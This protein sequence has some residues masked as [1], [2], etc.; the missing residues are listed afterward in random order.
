MFLGQLERTIAN[1]LESFH[2]QLSRNPGGIGGSVF[3]HRITEQYKVHVKLATNYFVEIGRREMEMESE[4]GSGSGSESTELELTTQLIIERYP[5]ILIS[6]RL[7]SLNWIWSNRKKLCVELQDASIMTCQRIDDLLDEIIR[8]PPFAEMYAKGIIIKLLEY[9]EWRDASEAF[10]RRYRLEWFLERVLQTS[11]HGGSGMHKV[12]FRSGG[13]RKSGSKSAET[14][15]MDDMDENSL[16]RYRIPHDVPIIFIDSEPGLVDMGTYV[17]DMRVVAIDCEWSPCF[18]ELRDQG[19]AL[20]QIGCE[21]KNG[22][23]EMSSR[24]LVFIID[25]LKADTDVSFRKALLKILVPMLQSPRI[26]KL[27]FGFGEDLKMLE[28]VCRGTGMLARGMQNSVDLASRD[29]EVVKSIQRAAGALKNSN[30]SRGNELKLNSL[31]DLAKHILGTKLDKQW[32]ISHW[33]KRPLCADQLEYA[34]GDVVV[35]LDLWEM[36]VKSGGGK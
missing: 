34:A 32:R 12:L 26:K 21:M 18:F 27:G 19:A 36:V 5:S 33:G 29:V 25:M 6:S 11:Y 8:G 15:D 22:D 7:G 17:P 35:L 10:A 4:G 31:S 28:N 23:G 16:P 24:R 30:N 9:Q 14:E 2:R 13:S 3:P 1:G 20:L